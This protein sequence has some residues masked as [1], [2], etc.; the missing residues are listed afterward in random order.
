M[1]A[2]TQ[3]F[4]A[5]MEQE[6]TEHVEQTRSG[7]PRA[8]GV[9]ATALSPSPK[10]APRGNLAEAADRPWSGSSPEQRSR[11]TSSLDA[12]ALLRYRREQAEAAAR[13]AMLRDSR[14][15]RFGI[16]RV[17]DAMVEAKRRCLARGLK[18]DAPGS[19]QDIELEAAVIL[20]VVGRPS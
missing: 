9:L 20:G 6:Y 13:A 5:R 3:A 4:V 8:R 10:T 11:R 14:L 1:L 7:A 18:L 12:D 16:A 17:A 15:V 19:K 2:D